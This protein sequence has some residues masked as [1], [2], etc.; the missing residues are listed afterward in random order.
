MITVNLDK[1]KAIALKT[2]NSL[3]DEAQRAEAAVQISNAIGLK[4]LAAVVE[5]IKVVQQ[6]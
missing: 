3:K 6:P 5:N 2:S 1:A 4:E